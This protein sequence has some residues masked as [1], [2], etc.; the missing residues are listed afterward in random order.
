MEPGAMKLALATEEALDYE[1]APNSE[2][3]AVVSEEAPESELV[4]NSEEALDLDHQ[5]S[6]AQ[7]YQHTT[8]T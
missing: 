4:P 2:E 7:S 1:V 5:T 6:L 3:V 8:S